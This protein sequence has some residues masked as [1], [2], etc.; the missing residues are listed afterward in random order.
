MDILSR[1]VNN[2]CF[3]Y[4]FDTNFHYFLLHW[5][6]VFSYN[7]S[8]CLTSVWINTISRS[9]C[10][11]PFRTWSYH[12]FLITSFSFIRNITSCDFSLNHFFLNI[13]DFYNCWSWRFFAIIT[14]NFSNLICIR[15]PFI[16]YFLNSFSW[17]S[18][19]FCFLFIF[20]QVWIRFIGNR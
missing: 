2:L 17:S 19:S 6:I 9:P 1:N 3:F 20:I 4:R 15:N 11:N 8:M 16:P 13:P 10:M 7:R 5:C 14:R 18:L 12:F